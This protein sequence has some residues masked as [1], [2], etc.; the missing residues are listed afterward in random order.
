M[1]RWAESFI[2]LRNRI[3]IDLG[4]V[5]EDDYFCVTRKIHIKK[6]K[7]KKKIIKLKIK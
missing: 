1:K 7:K 3:A 5:G 4:R 6:K 2:Y